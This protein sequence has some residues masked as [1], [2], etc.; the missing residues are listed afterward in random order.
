M[1]TTSPTRLASSMSVRWPSCSAPIV[2][3][4]EMLL[5][6][7][8]ALATTP[9]IS[10]IVSTASI[11]EAVIG[12]RINATAN[13]TRP[14]AD[15]RPNFLRHLGVALEELRVEGVIEAKDVRQH[16]HLPVAVDPGADSNRGNSYCFGNAGGN[17]IRHELEHH[18][19]RARFLEA[20]RLSDESRRALFFASLHA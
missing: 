9:R 19:K 11:L 4:N 8:R 7:A 13:F 1:T 2:G 12:V 6:F 15:R 3:T 20:L 10:E 14:V 5:P 17:R 16:Q 18:A